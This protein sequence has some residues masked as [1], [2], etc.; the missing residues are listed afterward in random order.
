MS[1]L[2]KRSSA[3]LR[4][5][6]LPLLISKSSGFFLDRLSM[7]PARMTLKRDL[8][9]AE[10]LDDYVDAVYGFRYRNVSVAPSQI[11]SEIKALLEVLAESPPRIVLEIGTGLGGTTLLLARVATEDAVIV[12]LDLPVGP[13]RQRLLGAGTQRGQTIHVVRDDSHQSATVDRV[14]SIIGGEQVDVLFMD[15]DHSYEGVQEDFRLYS[16]LVHNSG[17]VVF[18]DIVPGPEEFVG[19]VPEFWSH[20]KRDREVREFIHDPSQKG[21][22]IGLMRAGPP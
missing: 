16:P 4:E 13:S 1:R 14:Q 2:L 3:A 22:G 18:H 8:S 12:T 15:G 10:S 17:W 7:F 9:A 20:L 6:G 19:G 5:G 11:R 21:L